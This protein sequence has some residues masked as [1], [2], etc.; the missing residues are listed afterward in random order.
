[1]DDI[2]VKLRILSLVLARETPQKSGFVQDILDKHPHWHRKTDG[3]LDSYEKLVT[4]LADI[5]NRISEMS[6][7]H[8][9]MK[10]PLISKEFKQWST[11]YDAY[12]A[13][14]NCL[15]MDSYNIETG[16]DHV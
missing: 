16:S 14:E 3:L 1:M 15:V 9:L 12:N 11:K 10:M 5:C 13:K 6:H 2:R 8:F 4:E 7:N